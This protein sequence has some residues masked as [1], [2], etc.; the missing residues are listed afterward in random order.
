MV[1]RSGR[2]VRGARPCARQGPGVR[3]GRSVSG[4]R[5]REVIA[6]GPGDRLELPAR[7][8][9]TRPS[10][11]RGCHVPRGPSPAGR[12]REV[13]RVAADTWCTR[14]LQLTRRASK[15][16][17][18]G[19]GASSG[20]LCGARARSLSV[21]RGSSRPGGHRGARSSSADSG[22]SSRKLT[23]ANVTM[24]PSPTKRA[25]RAVLALWTSPAAAGVPALVT[26]PVSLPATITYES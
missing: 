19:P 8:G 26:V 14:A 3:G 9:T 22:S 20:R 15:R 25:M 13:R 10:A 16:P 2:P 5:P 23:T 4:C 1:E 6:L 12:L 24:R 7:R 18:R 17:R 11:R 21:E